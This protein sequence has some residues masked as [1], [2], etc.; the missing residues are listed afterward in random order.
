MQLSRWAGHL[1]HYGVS[2]GLAGPQVMM[3]AEAAAVTALGPGGSLHGGVP[4]P[5]MA[6]WLLCLY[7]DP[8]PIS[9]AQIQMS[10]LNAR[11]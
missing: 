8:V 5:T 11:M 2:P 4:G 1:V 7:L 6:G 9:S 10:S 3:A